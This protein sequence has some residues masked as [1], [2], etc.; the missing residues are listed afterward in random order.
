M[1]R[2]K[3][4][5][6][7]MMWRLL[8]RLGAQGITFVVSLILARLLD[9]SVYGVIA[10]VTV[11]TAILNVFIDSGLGN[12]LIQKKNADDLDFSSVFWFNI[13]SCSV[14]YLLM[15]FSAPLIADFYEIEELVPII[16]V[17]SITLLISGVKNIQQAY[18]SRSLA[19]KKFFY[20]TLVGTVGAAA[21]GIAMVFMGYGIWALVFQNLFN[22]AVDT[23]MLWF[24]V[25]W[26]PKFIFSFDRLKGLLKYG[27]KILA[28][29]LIDTVYNELRQL[30]IGKIY[31]TSDLAFYNQGRKFP[32][33]AVTAINESIDS[34]LFPTMSAVQDKKQEVKAMTRRAIK[35]STYVI[36]PIM[37]GIAACA[38]SLISLILTEKWLPAV[39]FLRIFCFTFAFYPIH[40]ANLNAIKAVGRSDIF[41]KLEIIKKVIGMTAIVS[42]MFISVKAMAMVLPLTSV[43]NQI[44]NSWPNKKL[45]DY[46]YIEQLRDM[47][48]QI[49]LSVFMF[50]AVLAIQYL[51]L[52]S[53]VTLLIQIPAGVLIYVLGSIIF[54]IDSFNYILKLIKSYRKTQ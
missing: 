6:D 21:V 15:F 52:N 50:G 11:F 32:N 47:L 25:K 28:S 44:V 18:V 19:F 46:S 39:F 8:E 12:A 45:L 38:S 4:V 1:D 40:T 5:A 53:I 43:L 35:T 23:V 17:M 41:L 29:K 42:T 9:P 16:R 48:P 22:Q 14:L 3:K 10:I 37:A 26:R 2:Q 33:Y 49:M 24:L 36:M 27:W 54:K 31:T 51:G 34:V 7:N 20:A 30:V 13:C